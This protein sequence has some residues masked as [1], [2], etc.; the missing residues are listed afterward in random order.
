[1]HAIVCIDQLR[2]DP[3]AIAA[4]ANAALEN[5]SDAELLR[6][7]ADIDRTPFVDEAGIAGDHPQPCDFRQGGDDILDQAVAEILLLRIAAHVLEWQ[8]NDGGFDR[9]RRGVRPARSLTCKRSDSLLPGQLVSPHPH[10]LDNIL[11]DLRPHVVEGDLDLSP[12]LSIGVIGQADAAGLGD[13][14]E[15]SCDIDAIAE[16]VVVVDDDV[17]D[18]DADPEF[19]SDILREVG[20]LPRHVAL[21]LHNATR[22]IDRAGELDQQAVTGGLD[23]ATAMRGDAGIDKRLSDS[24]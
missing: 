22:C 10:R 20:V 6:R 15:A 4:P 11:E 14:F 16:D 13:A 18:V 7:L 8:Y 1:M 5:I 21:D 23:D 9:K 17:A 19:D 2:R 24:L 3:N 12:D